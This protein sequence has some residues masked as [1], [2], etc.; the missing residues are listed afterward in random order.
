MFLR[1]SYI[2]EEQALL[3]AIHCVDLAPTWVKGYARKAQ[4][5]YLLKKYADAEA[6]C[7]AV[8]RRPSSGKKQQ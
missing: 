7:R 8:R 3:D 6:T 2:L 5:E 1:H 4:A